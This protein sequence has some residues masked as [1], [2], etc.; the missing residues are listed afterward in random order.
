MK[1]LAN[2]IRFLEADST[3]LKRRV[4][5]FTAFSTCPLEIESLI[6]KSFNNFKIGYKI[7]FRQHI[8]DNWPATINANRAERHWGMKIDY[9]LEKTMQTMLED[10]R[11]MYEQTN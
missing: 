5:N 8:A 10:V 6:A 9:D 4:Y 7:D 11:A 1:L 3:L 2:K